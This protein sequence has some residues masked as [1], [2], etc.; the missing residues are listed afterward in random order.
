MTDP[1]LPVPHARLLGGSMY[2]WLEQQAGLDL[3]VFYDPINDEGLSLDL[4]EW[5]RALAWWD[6]P[7]G[8]HASQRQQTDVTPA[9]PRRAQGTKKEPPVS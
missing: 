6:D 4:E 2:V 9:P 3:V 8:T 5:E 7:G 1:L